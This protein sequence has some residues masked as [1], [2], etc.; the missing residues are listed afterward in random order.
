MDHNRLLVNLAYYQDVPVQPLCQFPTYKILYVTHGS[1]RI[2][3][4]NRSFCIGPDTLLCM[5]NL[6]EQRLFLSERPCFRYLVSL[7]PTAFDLS[8]ADPQLIAIFKNPF[9]ERNIF[10]TASIAPVIKALFCDLAEEFSQQDKYSESMLCGLVH[11]LMVTISRTF[12][13]SFTELTT[14]IQ[15]TVFSAQQYI[16]KH[17]QDPLRVGDVASRFFLSQ[18]YLTHCFKE[19]TGYTPMQYLNLCRLS[20]SKS[21]L[22]STNL[23]INEIALQ[24]GF[25]DVNNFIRAFKKQYQTTPGQLRREVSLQFAPI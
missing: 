16:E 11:R 25:G 18:S 5:N 7:N 17:F 9:S 1:M 23:S 19:Y 24:S 13:A 15:T 21:L 20:Y 6:E 2:D 3:I 12:P 10:P 14:G 8:I 4:S 22:L